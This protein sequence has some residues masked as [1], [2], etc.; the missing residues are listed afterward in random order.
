MTYDYLTDLAT[1]LAVL[2]ERELL[3]SRS[4]IDGSPNFAPGLLAWLEHGV[5]WEIDRRMGVGYQLLRPDAAID[6]TDIDSSLIALAVLSA[7]FRGDGR[8]DSVP[9]ADFL[10]LTAT[11][12]L[13]EI[14][15]PGTLQ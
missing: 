15:R 1:A 6:D 14:E 12:L 13:A 5:G 4:A 11:V 2:G 10:E 8:T 7:C 3:G 9:V